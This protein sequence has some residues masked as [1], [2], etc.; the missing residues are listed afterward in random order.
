V[1]EEGA[2]TH[3]SKAD[4]RGAA[5]RFASRWK[6]ATSEQADRQSFWNDFFHVFGVERRQVAAFERLATRASTGAAVGSICF[7]RDRSA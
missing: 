6:D 4:I 5:I 2:A 3:A 7:G 1:I